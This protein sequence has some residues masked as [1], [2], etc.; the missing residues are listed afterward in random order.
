[1]GV[2]IVFQI[3]RPPRG[4]AS[5]N[6]SIKMAS[7]LGSKKQEKK[8]SFAEDEDVIEV[9]SGSGGFF[10]HET[11]P[12]RSSSKER[13]QQKRRPRKAEEEQRATVKGSKKAGNSARSKKSSGS[14]RRFVNG[15]ATASTLFPI[16]A[17]RALY[18][19]EVDGI[20]D[21][22][23]KG[24]SS[25]DAA[26]GLRAKATAAAAAAAVAAATRKK[27]GAPRGAVNQMS[28]AKTAGCARVR[29]AFAHAE[30]ARARYAG[31]RPQAGAR[32]RRV[33]VVRPRW[34]QGGDDVTNL[35]DEIEYMDLGAPPRP[36]D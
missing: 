26:V 11:T 14:D 12:R 13:M 21:F 33:E 35:A 10:V 27:V 18:L 3:I 28:P 29:A 24:L 8:V 30:A 4:N 2:G 20:A 22:V 34:G 17:K 5:T 32:Q 7:D 6:G 31:A 25:S 19:D 36:M 23:D 16:K 9:G 1:M 15:E